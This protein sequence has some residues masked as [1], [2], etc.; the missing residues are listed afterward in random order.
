MFTK[1]PAVPALYGKCRNSSKHHTH[2]RERIESTIISAINDSSREKRNLESRSFFSKKNSIH[3][4]MD[5]G[6][7]MMDDGWWMMDDGWWM[8]DDGWWMMDDGW[9]MMDDGWWM[10]DDGWTDGW[11]DGRTDGWMEDHFTF[12]FTLFCT[13]KHLWV[14]RSM[15]GQMHRRSH[16]EYARNSWVYVKS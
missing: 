15:D 11:T 7:W 5:D 9:W 1:R 3:P 8:M 16:P 2:I 13:S 6:W 10:M 4:G 14:R 12:C